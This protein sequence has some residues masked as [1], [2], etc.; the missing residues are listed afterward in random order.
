MQP[1]LWSV[2]VRTFI[3]SRAHEK[4]QVARDPPAA[5]A[6]RLKAARYTC[7]GLLCMQILTT[8]ACCKRLHWVQT[9]GTTGSL[10]LLLGRPGHCS[11]LQS[12]QPKTSL[13]DFRAHT[14]R[15]V[16]EA[17]SAATMSALLCTYRMLAFAATV[18]VIWYQLWLHAANNF[19]MIQ[20]FEAAMRNTYRRT[21]SKQ[22]TTLSNCKCRTSQHLMRTLKIGIYLG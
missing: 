22:L 4:S 9:S 13:Q 2:Q 11:L 8:S 5:S 3:T 6:L 7:G 17:L 16:C 10:P 15:H 21:L 12:C 19:L 1:L 14:H 20:N 18:R